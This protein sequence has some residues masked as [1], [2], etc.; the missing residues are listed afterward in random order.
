MEKTEVN[1]QNHG[2]RGH[3]SN[4]TPAE[5]RELRDKYALTQAA[6]AT[7]LYT[8]TRSYQQWESGDRRMHPAFFELLSLKA[9]AG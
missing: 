6:A 3:N 2:Q 4:P 5:V 8:S 1:H 7:M 9:R